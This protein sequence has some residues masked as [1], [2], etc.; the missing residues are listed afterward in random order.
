[1]TN[2]WSCAHETNL[3]MN[4][5]LKRPWILMLILLGMC[6][7]SIAFTV[8]LPKALIDQAL[9]AKFPK[10]RY[11]IQLDSP[12]TRFKPDTQRVELCGV[13]HLNAPLKSGDFCLD[14]KPVWNKDKGEIQMSALNILKF[15]AGADQVLPAPTQQILNAMVLPLLDGTAIY[16]VPSVVGQRLDNFKIDTNAFDLVF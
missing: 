2:V 3:T 6:T 11:G 9:A 16:H 13:W 10:E 5:L 15:T 8:P 12:V 7:D 1:M 14:F 4:F